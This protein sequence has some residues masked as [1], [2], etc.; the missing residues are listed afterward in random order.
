MAMKAVA[1]VFLPCFLSLVSLGGG[2]EML[3]QATQA[4]VDECGVAAAADGVVD[5]SG[6]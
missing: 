2:L 4:P 1:P 6:W 5:A 3:A